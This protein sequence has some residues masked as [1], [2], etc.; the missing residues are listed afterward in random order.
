MSNNELSDPRDLSYSASLQLCSL[1]EVTVPQVMP[2]SI[3][4]VLLLDIP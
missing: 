2:D 3:V 4:L 1:S